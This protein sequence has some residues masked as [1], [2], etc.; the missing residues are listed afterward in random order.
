MTPPHLD[1]FV[2][3]FIE[4]LNYYYYLSFLNI[5]NFDYFV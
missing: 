4:Y 5:I 1:P 3:R 2:G